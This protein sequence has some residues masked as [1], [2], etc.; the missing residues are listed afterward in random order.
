[1]NGFVT[2]GFIG[3]F[4][5]YIFDEFCPLFLRIEFNRVSSAVSIY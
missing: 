3:V 1:M 4:V 5:F 2:Y